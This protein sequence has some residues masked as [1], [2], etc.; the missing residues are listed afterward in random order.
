MTNIT[1]QIKEKI[2][3]AEFLKEY[4]QL[5]PAGRNFKALCPFHKESNPSFVISPDRQTWYCFGGCNDGGD[6][7]KF[8]MKFENLEFYEALKILAEKAGVDFRR[9]PNTAA[10]YKTIWDSL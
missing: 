6:I 7:F 1:D 3:I 4:I 10:D 5:T 8:L 2:D 9:N